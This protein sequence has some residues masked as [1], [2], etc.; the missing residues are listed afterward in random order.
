[1]L[2]Q[3]QMVAATL[4]DLAIQVSIGAELLTIRVSSEVLIPGTAEVPDLFN[5]LAESGVESL[6]E[7]DTGVFI[8][9]RSPTGHLDC[10]D[11]GIVGVDAWP[12]HTGLQLLE[13]ECCVGVVT[14]LDIFMHV[15]RDSAED[16][17]AEFGDA[18]EHFAERLLEQVLAA[19]SLHDLLDSDDERGHGHFAAVVGEA[20]IDGAGDNGGDWDFFEFEAAARATVAVAGREG[21]L[22]GGAQG[23]LV[24]KVEDA[25]NLAEGLALGKKRHLLINLAVLPRYGHDLGFLAAG[26]ERRGAFGLHGR[27]HSLGVADLGALDEGVHGPGRGAGEGGG[28]A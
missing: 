20:R 7:A 4:Q 5:E 26:R 22:V 23:G 27:A 12:L 9:Q 6:N 2:Y 28:A 14:L 24:N 18:M 16:P 8:E 25:G 19:V 15:K 10:S 21:Q 11:E 1:M 17:V 13:N 3:I